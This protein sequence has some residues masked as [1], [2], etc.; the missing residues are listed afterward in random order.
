MR[1]ID[2]EAFISIHTLC[3][4]GDPHTVRGIRH[5]LNFN[6]HPLWRGRQLVSHFYVSTF[7]ISI[8]TL[9]EEGDIFPLNGFIIRVNF[10]PHPLWRGRH[11]LFLSFTPKFPFQSTP[12]VKRATPYPQQPLFVFQ[13][14]IHTLCEEGDDVA[15]LAEDL[16]TISIHTLCEEGDVFVLSWQLPSKLFQST[17]SVKRATSSYASSTGTFSISIHTLCEE[18]DSKWNR[19]LRTA[20]RFQSTPSV[21]RATPSWL[22]AYAFRLYFN[23]HPLW[24]GRHKSPLALSW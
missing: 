18:G 19:N 1:V 22:S 9:C 6:P 7:L 21:K 10:N 20:L 11:A 2:A 3:E 14:S 15:R 23:P 5:T 24:R 17:P 12:S 13:I 16:E 4:E 8:H